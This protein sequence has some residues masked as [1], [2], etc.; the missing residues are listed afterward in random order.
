MH[1][2]FDI[3][4]ATKYG[5]R[6]AILLQNFIYW[7]AKNAA[8]GKNYHDGRYW[9][10]NSVAALVALFPFWT[11]KQIRTIL[12]SLIKQG[13]LIEGNYN[14]MKYDR[15]K[16][17]ALGDEIV[18]CTRQN[19]KFDSPEEENPFAQM[20]RPIPDNKPDKKIDTYIES[21]GDAKRN[22]SRFTPP[23]LEEV[24]A[25]CE[26]R[27][28]LLNPRK[29]WDYYEA[30]GWMVGRNKMKDWRAAVRNWE[31]REKEQR[32]GS[33]RNIDPG[34]PAAYRHRGRGDDYGPSTI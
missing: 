21:K 19:W 18:K 13:C 29:F 8:N 31:A 17:Y 28:N 6:E 12:A 30:N 16:W 23:T 22:A 1:Y 32:N 33:T 34:S 26:E 10:Y 27:F 14:E 15:T 11:Y 20:G 24:T 3:E 25:Y 9:T 4:L 5:D 2:S 7:I